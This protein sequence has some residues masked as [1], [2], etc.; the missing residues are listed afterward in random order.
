[1]SLHFD[2]DLWGPVDPNIFYPLRHEVKRNPLAFMAFGNGPRY[3]IG[4]KFALIEIKAVLCKLLLS[5]E[6]LPTN[7]F[8]GDIELVEV[9][10]RR[11]KNGLKILLKRRQVNYC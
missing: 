6:F 11:P 3:C 1:M 10:V 8:Q 9:L 4:M 2:Q 5:Y 7:D